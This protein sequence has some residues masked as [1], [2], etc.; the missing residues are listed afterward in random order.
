MINDCATSSFQDK[1]CSACEKFA[2]RAGRDWCE[3]K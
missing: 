1:R 2:E 3:S